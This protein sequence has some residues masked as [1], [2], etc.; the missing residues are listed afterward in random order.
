MGILGAI[1]SNFKNMKK[2]KQLRIMSEEEWLCLDEE[3]FYDAVFCVCNDAVYDIK[4]ANL[5]QEQVNVY[6]LI[7][8]EIEV[9]NGGLCQ[10]FVNSSRE[11]APYLSKALE[12]IGAFEMKE[13][14][15]SFVSQN[16]ID[17]NNLESFVINSAD[18][19]DAQTERF[20]FDFFD[21]KF[22]ENT[23]LHGQI[24]AYAKKN[25]SKII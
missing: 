9:N 12:T 21:D 22:Y 1:F 20:D 10:F 18:E 16:A 6:S 2:A 23:D 5:T 8:F 17:L 15:D 14:F 11:C 24:I 19:Y 25:I 3:D 13:L 4:A 7:N